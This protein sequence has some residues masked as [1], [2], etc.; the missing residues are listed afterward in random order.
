L[1]F[2][3]AQ[4]AQQR[5]ELP[6]SSTQ[7]HSK[8]TTPS[9][10]STNAQTCAP[11]AAAPAAAAP[12]AAAAAAAVLRLHELAGEMQ[13]ALEDTSRNHHQSLGKAARKLTEIQAQMTVS[14]YH[15]FSNLGQGRQDA[16]KI[17]VGQ[18]P[19]FRGLL[20]TP[21]WEEAE[22][23]AAAQ[24]A[25]GEAPQSPSTAT[26]V[27]SSAEAAQAQEGAGGPDLSSM[28]AAPL[29]LLDDAVGLL[30]VGNITTAADFTCGKGGQQWK[31][32]S[33]T[34][35]KAMQIIYDYEVHEAAQRNVVYVMS[36][37]PKKPVQK[38][39]Q[40][41]LEGL[42]YDSNDEDPGL[43]NI[44]GF[45]ETWSIADLMALYN[46]MFVSNRS[47]FMATPIAHL[48]WKGGP[49]GSY[50]GER[51]FVIVTKRMFTHCTENLTEMIGE[52]TKKRK[53]GFW[54]LRLGG[55]D[56]LP[57]YN[58][59]WNHLEFNDK[60]CKMLCIVLSPIPRE[61]DH[62]H[63]PFQAAWEAFAHLS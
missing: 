24:V 23:W 63:T 14:V 9:T 32:Q 2:I 37:V 21:S 29:E 46:Q 42:K 20:Q 40:L 49:L 51:L 61:R 8:P 41:Y 54:K 52:L 58:E 19:T 55:L 22:I 26:G 48:L 4:E 27:T 43:N 10:S 59:T 44:V 33:V 12:P 35:E 30:V 5:V 34:D 62:T 57:G 56:G 53:P 16:F 11:A 17:V 39:L 1:K 18:F 47:A 6:N 7:S 13:Q 15:H 36:A 25:A 50:L 31:T 38:K 45:G 3:E 28:P 60:R